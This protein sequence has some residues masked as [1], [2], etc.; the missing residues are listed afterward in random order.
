M[1]DM[2]G[3]P[4]PSHASA[5]AP[6]LSHSR[7]PA[8]ARTLPPQDR[9]H[10][11][12]HL[13]RRQP[14]RQRPGGDRP[15]PAGLCRMGRGGARPA[16]PAPDAA[17]PARPA[18]R[19]APRAGLRRAAAV[20]PAEHPRCHRH[21]QH[22]ALERAQPVPRLPGLR[23]WPHGAVGLQA[24]PLSRRPQ[25]AGGRD[26]P[27]RQLLLQRLRRPYRAGRRRLRRPGGRGDARPCRGQPAAGGG[28]DHGPRAAGAGTRGLRGDGGRGGH[29]THPGGQRAPTRSPPCAAP[30]MPAR[31]RWP[32]W[33]PS[34]GPKSPAAG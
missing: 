27:R 25:P 22:A 3:R 32:G 2:R 12:R 24:G 15:H 33:R 13:G 8:H 7:S 14:Q 29:R 5:A 31:R 17:L 26:P 18:R 16:R 4:Q 9:P 20:R 21:H 30:I 34:P 23:R 10:A 28:Q 11:R 6:A 1:S 19:C